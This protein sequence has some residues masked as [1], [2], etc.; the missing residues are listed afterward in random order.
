MSESLLNQ[1]QTPDATQ[2]QAT[3]TT[4]TQAPEIKIPDNWKQAIPEEFRADPSLEAINDF[5]SLVKSYVNA[6][7]MI[8]ADKIVVPHKH[9]DGTLFREAMY[10]LGLPKN[11]DEFKIEADGVD[12]QLL[13]AFKEKAYEMGVLPN[14]A[15]AIFKE[16]TS[17]YNELNEK[18]V[19]EYT[20]QMVEKQ[21]ALKKEWGEAYDNKITIA[22]NAAKFLAGQDEN[23]Y[24]D[25]MSAEISGH[26]SVVKL[27][28]KVG[29]MLKEDD[30][31]TD[32]S[33]K[34]GKTPDE[35]QKEINSIMGDKTHPYNNPSHPNHE[36]A[37]LEVNGLWKKIV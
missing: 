4:Q 28:A 13:T 11:K 32:N 29:D 35:I 6:Q 19:N 5:S 37:V 33:Q 8:G 3:D 10:K 17:K 27:L 24:N 36:K 34:W 15:N 1:V 20:S 7:R 30:L 2:T 31:I 9:D 22:A 18:T 25:I 12:E 16:L 14:Q 26:P 23:L 21:N